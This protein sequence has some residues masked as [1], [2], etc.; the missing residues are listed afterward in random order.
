MAM[1]M[2]NLLGVRQ[3]GVPCTSGARRQADEAERVCKA[4]EADHLG[5]LRVV[6]QMVTRVLRHI[7]LGGLH[8]VCARGVELALPEGGDAEDVCALDEEHA[9]SVAFAATV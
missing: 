7:A 3:C 8:E 2:R 1:W 5:I 6:Q 9:A 4:T